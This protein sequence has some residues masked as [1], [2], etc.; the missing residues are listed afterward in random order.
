MAASMAPAILIAQKPYHLSPKTYPQRTPIG[1]ST[2]RSV[3]IASSSPSFRNG[4]PPETECPVPWDQQPVNEYQALSSSFPFSLASANL[5]D[6]CIRLSFLG[7]SFAILV[8]LPVAT[9]GNSDVTNT[10]AVALSCGLGAA[11]SGILFVMLVVLRMYLGWAYVGNRLLSA[12]V[13]YEET[14]WYDG[15]IWVK[16]PDVLTRD[17]LLGSYSFTLIGLAISLAVCVI[18]LVD[19]ENPKY[20]PVNTK[21]KVIAG[22]YNEE[23]ARSFEPDAFCGDSDLS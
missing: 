5:R 22:V 17:R 10:S 20:I 6:Y 7:S 19:V 8:G 2:K 9:F 14:G 21:G 11:S 16:T 15:Q 4:S 12:T 13:D 18:I 23:A 1:S 3:T